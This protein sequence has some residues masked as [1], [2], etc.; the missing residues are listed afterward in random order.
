M[1]SHG[2]FVEALLKPGMRLLDLGCGPGTITLDLAARV[3][4]LSSVVGVDRSE[5]QFNEARTVAGELPVTF[6]AMDAYSLELEDESFDGVFAHALFEHLSQP[7]EALREVKRVLKNDGFVAL[8]SPDWGGFVV[9]PSDEKL[10]AAIRARMELQTR[11]GGD[12][13]AGKNWAIG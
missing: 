8:R 12:V 5:T 2:H 13:Y 1:A 10:A 11:N 6:G 3:G 7:L 4:T 9:H